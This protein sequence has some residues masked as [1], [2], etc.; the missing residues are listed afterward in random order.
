MSSMLLPTLSRYTS[1]VRRLPLFTA[2][3]IVIVTLVWFPALSLSQ[4]ADA[5]ILVAEGILAFDANQFDEAR[6]F[7]ARA[8]SLPHVQALPF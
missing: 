4:Q 3:F 1:T 6:A 7:F 8:L 5:E 2:A